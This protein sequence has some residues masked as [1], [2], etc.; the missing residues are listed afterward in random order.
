MSRVAA[1]EQRVVNLEG[2]DEEQ[3]S[4]INRIRDRPPYWVT[5]IGTIGGFAIGFLLNAL[6]N[7][8]K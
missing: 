2:S 7:C 1:L 8:L 5:V 3:W 4:Q 6:L